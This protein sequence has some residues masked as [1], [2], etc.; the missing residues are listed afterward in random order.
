MTILNKNFLLEQGPFL[1]LVYRKSPLIMPEGEW[2]SKDEYEKDIFFDLADELLGDLCLITG[3][4]CPF[5][6]YEVINLSDTE[7][8]QSVRNTFANWI[9]IITNASDDKVRRV[10]SGLYEKK[11]IPPSD[12]RRDV[13]DT[14]EY[15][16]SYLS[17][18]EKKG[19]TITIIGI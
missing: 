6:P 2:P 9:K 7:S 11:D 8:I 3:Q 17:T 5:S 4:Y 13:L 1:N 16:M 12:I 19:D 15:I 14:L 18:A 10:F